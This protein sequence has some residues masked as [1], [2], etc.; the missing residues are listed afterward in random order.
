MSNKTLT[1]L[2]A[3]AVLLMAWS[4]YLASR[5]PGAAVEFQSGHYLLPPYDRDRI[6]GIEIKK[7]GKTVTMT[8][9]GR[10]FVVSSR[11]SYPADGGS[12]YRLIADLEGIKCAAEISKSK[13]THAEQGVVETNEEA[14]TIRLLDTDNKELVGVIVGKSGDKRNG[15]YVR[16]TNEDT[17]YVSTEFLSFDS[18]D[19][20][21]L[22]KTILDVERKD[23]A[24]V[25]VKGKDRRPYAIE[26]SKENDVKLVAVPAGKKSKSYDT[27]AVFGAATSLS[28]DDFKAASEM[29]DL[30]FD[31]TYTITKRFQPSYDFFIAKKD[32]KCWVRCKAVWRGPDI[33]EVRTAPKKDAKKEELERKDKLIE[34]AK[35]IDRFNDRHQSWVYEIPSY[36]AEDMLKKFEDLVEDVISAS[37]ILIGFEGADRSEVKGRTKEEA[38]KK[39]EELLVKVKAAPDKAVSDKFAELAKEHSDGPSKDKG[40]DLGEFNRDLMA[41]PFTEVAFKLKVGE[42]SGVVETEFGF[43]IILRTK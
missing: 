25:E 34:G 31:T 29:A 40:G 3:I 39:A 42:I 24:K 38:K 2:G 32:D 15:N 7:A 41:K 16:L 43:H 20:D 5:G 21:Y 10:R 18:E 26:S 30:K 12:I 22:D 27:E 17:V 9:Q 35:E 1:I 4:F 36:K 33:N 8:R 28:F 19:S 11:L 13:D 6:A 37:H 23:I 14:V